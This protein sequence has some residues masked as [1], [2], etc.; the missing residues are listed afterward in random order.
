MPEQKLLPFACFRKKIVPLEEAKINFTSYSL[1]YGAT[2]FSGIRGYVRE[3]TVRVFRLYDHFVRLANGAKILGLKFE[4]S[5]D[6][7]KQLMVQVIQANAP[8]HDF[9]IRPFIFTESPMLNIHF[10][11]QVFDLG[12]Y[13][14]QIS[15]VFDPLKGLR[16]MVSSWGKLPDNYIPTKA[17]AGGAYVNS[18]LAK[19]EAMQNGYDDALMLDGQGNVVE[20]S[21]A[22]IFIV[23]RGEVLMPE[24]GAAMLEGITRRTMAEILEEEGYKVKEARIDRSMLFTCDELLLT[25]TLVQIAYAASVNGRTIALDGK[26]GH[27]CKLL[28]K[29]FHDVIDGNYP[30]STHWITE[31]PS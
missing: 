29:K 4:M 21:I 30:R 17:K 10:E 7:F 14:A 2:C 31:I 15:H 13:L 1:Q 19:S 6:E 23:Y 25:G 11:K 26:P 20:A 3:G 16:L 24:T 12:I 22:N 9:Y 27:F 18:A 8:Q 28:R 5:W